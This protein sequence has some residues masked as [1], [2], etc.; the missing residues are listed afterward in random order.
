MAVFGIEEWTVVAEEAVAVRRQGRNIRKG[1]Q[2][3]GEVVET[4]PQRGVVEVQSWRT[5]WL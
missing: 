5:I 2:N 3:W 1:R 4:T